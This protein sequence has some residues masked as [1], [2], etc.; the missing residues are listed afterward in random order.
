M[1]LPNVSSIFTTRESNS[2]RVARRELC[3]GERD[4][5]FLS[6]PR[7]R[8][9][10]LP[11]HFSKRSK[12]SDKCDVAPQIADV[13]GRWTRRPELK[14]MYNGHDEAWPYR[15]SEILGFTTSLRASQIVAP[16]S[17]AASS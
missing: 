5:L 6:E 7:E 3:L 11:P 2:W 12:Q 13:I 9:C 16:N 4:I 14:K 1:M 15:L 8:L 17:G 10:I